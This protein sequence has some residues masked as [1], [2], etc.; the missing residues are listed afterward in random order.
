LHHEN[1]GDPMRAGR[2]WMAGLFL[3]AVLGGA[4][5]G[6]LQWY[7]GNT[8][9]HTFWSDG[10]EFP[11]TVAD[12]Y[13]KQGYH[14]LAL[15]DHNTFSVGERWMP[16]SRKGVEAAIERSVTRWGSEHLQF[17]AQDGTTNKMVRVRPLEE[18]RSLVEE[19]GRFILI[20]SLELTSSAAKG[21]Q[22]HSNPLNVHG[23]KSPDLR[24]QDKAVPIEQRLALH[25]QVVAQY[26]A[27]GSSPVF[28]S[29]NHPNYQNSLKAQH[30]LAVTNANAVEILNTTRGCFNEGN[31]A[32][33]QPVEKIWDEANTMRLQRGLPPLFGMAVDDT[34]RYDSAVPVL[35]GP[36]LAW[37]MVH[38]PALTADAITAAMARGDFYCSSGITLDTV[39]FDPAARTLTIAIS[40]AP[41]VNYTIR[42]VGSVRKDGAVQSGQILQTTPGL[43]AV[44]QM[45][46]NELF[47]RA[48]VSC[49]APKILTY[50]N[51]CDLVPKAW[52]QPVG[53]TLAP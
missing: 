28:W 23:K 38:S 22:V 34:H 42:F 1:K 29:I 40:P 4:Q 9:T 32:A 2:Q 52:T 44:Y 8:H 43:R 11:E 14:F 7:R 5:A 24:P 25:E 26:R 46:G 37:I 18:V 33:I 10:G 50:D 35:N 31:K 51:F 27:A 48:V 6:E 3:A 49:D 12:Y 45:T 13:K 20:E 21:K 30:L 36:G 19:P 47:V 39:D 53:W 41:G 15:T 17:R 16:L